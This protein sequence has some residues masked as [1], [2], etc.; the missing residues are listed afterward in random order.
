MTFGSLFAG[1]GGIDLGFERAGLECRWQAEIDPYATRV[2][3]RHWPHVRRWGDVRTFPP[4]GPVEDWRVDVIA[5]GF[6]CQDISNAGKRRGIDGPQSGLWKDFARVL[7]VLR[8]RYVVVENT[9]SLRSRGLSRVLA[10]LAALGYDAE[11]SVVSCCSLGAPHTRERLFVLAHADGPGVWELWGQ[12]AQ[13]VREAAR[14]LC[15]WPG[16]PEPVRVADGVPARLDRLRCCGNAVMPQAAELIGR[17]LLYAND[18]AKRQGFNDK[19]TAEKLRAK[20]KAAAPAPAHSNPAPAPRSAE[21]QLVA[22]LRSFVHLVGKDAARSLLN[23]MVDR[24]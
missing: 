24:L 21:G 23:D 6:P 10:D 7:G 20:A 3:E 8:P 16:G 14:H 2:L 17:G 9:A 15:R 19:I 18:L 12:Q 1:I 22:N 4:P 13:E 11:W 5:G